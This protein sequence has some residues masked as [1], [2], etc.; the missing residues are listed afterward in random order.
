MA[1]TPTTRNRFNLQGT[2]DNAGTW[3]GVLNGQ[4]LALIDE[5]LDGITSIAVAGNV[6]LTSTNYAT[7]QARRR[8]LKLT[9]SPGA[10]YTVTV[11]SVEKF[12]VVINST[13]APQ[14]I[15]AGGLGVTIPAAVMTHVVCDGTD[16][17]ARPG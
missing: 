1:S 7:D 4:A 3:G 17:F 16:C 9:G 10:T 2:G 15:K 6:S 14:T 11:P 13:N 5:A 8:T 12:Y